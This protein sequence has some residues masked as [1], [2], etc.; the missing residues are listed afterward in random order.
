MQLK[1]LR[2][3]T[4]WIPPHAPVRGP[5]EI[6]RVENF[7]ATVLTCTRAVP[8]PII[9]ANPKGEDPWTPIAEA[10]HFNGIVAEVAVTAVK[11]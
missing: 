10:H 11:H 9:A 7:A 8:I 1:S 2:Y 4:P 3:G 5:I 6:A